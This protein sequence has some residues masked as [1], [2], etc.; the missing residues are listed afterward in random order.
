[1][2]ATVF[3][4]AAIMAVFGVLG[5]LKGS[6][7]TFYALL[8]L[9]LV[10]IMVEGRSGTIVSTINGLYLGMMLTLKG[11]L[12]AIASGDLDK[13]KQLIEDIQRPVTDANKSMVMLL[14]IFAAAGLALLLSMSTKS[15]PSAMGLFLGMLYGYMLSAAALPLIITDANFKLPVP[16]LRAVEPGTAAAT[17]QGASALNKVYATLNQ[18]Q[19]VRIF[20]LLIGIL[21]VVILLTSVRKG[22]G[23]SAGGQK[24]G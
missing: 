9:V 24:K 1:M 19:N 12:G 18:P 6:R 21:I 8:L 22:A 7:W 4:L 14:V 15:K 17:A 10:F 23:S 3:L 5:Y 11:G 2:F 20:G 13:A 16:F